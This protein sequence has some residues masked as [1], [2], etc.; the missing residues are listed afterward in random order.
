MFQFRPEW[1]VPIRQSLRRLFAGKGANSDI[2]SLSGITG[3][4]ST[5]SYVDVATGTSLATPA[6]HHRLGSLNVDGVS[7]PVSKSP[8][9]E[10]RLSRDRFYTVKNVSGITLTK[11]TL[12]YVNGVASAAE[13]APLT[14]VRAQSNSMTTMP[15]AGV[16]VQDLANN[17]VGLACVVGRIEGLN[18]SAFAAQDQLFVS[19]TVAG[20]FTNVRPSTPNRAQPVAQVINSHATN[21]SII[22]HIRTILNESLSTVQNSF[23]IG[24][25]TAGIKSLKFAGTTVRSLFDGATVPTGQLVGDT[26]T[27]R[28]ATTQAIVG[29][30]EWNG[31]YWLSL[32]R[33]LVDGNGNNVASFNAQ[34][35]PHVGTDLFIENV[36]VIGKTSAT[37][38]GTAYHQLNLY[39]FNSDGANTQITSN[40]FNTSAIAANASFSRI[41]LIN[42]FYST[43]E[44]TAGQASPALPISYFVQMET[45]VGTPGNIPRANLVIQSR[46]VRR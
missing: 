10:F 32:Q 27:E 19:P 44:V 13:N 22:V 16:L 31:T 18:T 29:Q 5:A 28:N 40:I 15:A 14:V 7:V 42:T 20:A 25:A 12:V 21:G 26:W 6:S 46:R 9:F 4:I 37:N 39:L 17:A 36:S 34:I 24:D 2:T 3:P 33:F 8:T 43:P 30:W 1:I 23:T 11:G 45:G 41:A 35:R 38:S